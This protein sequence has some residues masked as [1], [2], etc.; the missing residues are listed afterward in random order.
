MKGFTDEH[1]LTPEQ[2]HFNT[3]LNSARLVAENAFE[4]LKGRWRCLLK[5]NEV[6]A[7]FMPDVVTACCILHNVCELNKEAFLPEWTADFDEDLQQPDVDLYRDT[8]TDSAR[9]IRDTMVTIV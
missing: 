4:R 2:R 8:L 7:A 6:D 3:Q 5:R 9:A 1:S